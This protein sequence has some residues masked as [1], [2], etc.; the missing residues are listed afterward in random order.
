MRTAR[1]SSPS[2]A[3]RST[4]ACIRLSIAWWLI[5]MTPTRLFSCT[6]RVDHVRAGERLAGAGRALDRDEA[7]VEV[8][9]P[10]ADRLDTRRRTP[11]PSGPS[12]GH[13]L[14]RVA[15]Q[16]RMTHRR[17]IA[18]EHP[19]GQVAQGGELGAFGEVGE[20]D[21]GCRQHAPVDHLLVPRSPRTRRR[22]DRCAASVKNAHSCSVSATII[23]APGSMSGSSGWGGNEN[24][25]AGHLRFVA[26][27]GAE[28]GP[29]SPGTRCGRS[30]RATR[31]GRDSSAIDNRRQ[32]AATT[33][34]S[35]RQ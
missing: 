29:R 8:R 14:C 13:E 1:S 33:R 28:P 19:V 20:V 21:Q 34:R 12:S 4:T 3:K 24:T 23:F 18:G 16:D 30:R 7:A 17:R 9:R 25:A 10:L 27:L 11:P 31:P 6:S 26:G 35:R 32:S 5:A 2:S 15:A 22:R